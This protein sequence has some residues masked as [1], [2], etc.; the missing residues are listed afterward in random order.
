MVD[1]VFQQ[2]Y[3]L[4]KGDF[5]NSFLGGNVVL[6]DSTS[7]KVKLNK[8][9]PILCLQPDKKIKDWKNNFPF[10]E[11]SVSTSC[12]VSDHLIIYPK[13]D[14]L[15]VFIIELKSK[16][17]NGAISQIRA[18]FELSKYIC[19]TAVRLLNYPSINIEYRGLIFSHKPPRKGTSKPVQTYTEDTISN[20]LYRH[21]QSGNDYDL[22]ILSAKKI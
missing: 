8:K 9:G 14:T 2:L 4:I 15:Y 7:K 21:L 5:K 3:D 13:T 1:K 20:L 12:S 16:N 22:D 10:F 19:G 11:T 17:V 18:S 6:Q